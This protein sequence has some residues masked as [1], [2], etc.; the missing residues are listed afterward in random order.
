MLAALETDP[1]RGA[2][3]FSFSKYNTVEEIDYTVE[4]LA[5]FFRV[6]V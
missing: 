2:I 3:R 4:K 5:E 6:K 1:N